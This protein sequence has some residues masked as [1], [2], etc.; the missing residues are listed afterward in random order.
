MLLDG[1]KQ[2]LKTCQNTARSLNQLLAKGQN[3]DPE[4]EAPALL[5]PLVLIPQS[6]WKNQ[7]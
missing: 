1:E 5:L 2:N 4:T 6:T 3:Q 7:K